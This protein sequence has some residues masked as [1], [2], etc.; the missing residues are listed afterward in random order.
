MNTCNENAPHNNIN[1]M[2]N[3]PYNIIYVNISYVIVLSVIYLTPDI[4]LF[5]QLVTIVCYHYRYTYNL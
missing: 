3:I 2:Y 5:L 4:N 1:M